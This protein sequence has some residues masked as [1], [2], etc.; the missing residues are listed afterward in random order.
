[1]GLTRRLLLSTLALSLFF[2][3]SSRA[4]KDE[5][6]SKITEI[7]KTVEGQVGVAVVDLST[8]DTLIYNVHGIFPMQSVFKF[9]LALAVLKKVDQGKLSLSKKIKLTNRD[10]LPNTWSPLREKYATGNAEVTVEEILMYTVTHSDNNGCDIL[11]RLL[12][13]PKKVNAFIHSLG[14]EEIAIKHNEEEMHKEWDVQFDNWSK[15]RSMLKLLELF[16]DKKL[17]SPSSHAILWKMMVETSTGPNRIKGLLPE[18]TEVLHRTGT[19]G[20]NAEGVT[21]AINDVG[22][23]K[24]PNGKYFAIVIYLGRV[25]GDVPALEKKIAEISR[26]VYQSDWLN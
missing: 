21:G 20:Q 1:M 14:V 10:L 26:T 8:R 15:T 22:I 7:A 2:I 5:L 12:G 11:F 13:G 6:R 25:K 17:L 4:Q 3:N 9:P 23:V 19:G 16:Y 18:S 24:L